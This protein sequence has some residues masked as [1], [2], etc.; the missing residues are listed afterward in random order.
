MRQSRVECYCEPERICA[1]GVRETVRTVKREFR[2][3][4][5]IEGGGGTR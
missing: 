3:V 5:A 4:L 2:S 1:T